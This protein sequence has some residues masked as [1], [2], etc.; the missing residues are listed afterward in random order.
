MTISQPPPEQRSCTGRPLPQTRRP[1]GLHRSST[2]W[3]AVAAAIVAF[4]YLAID[5]IDPYALSIIVYA[6]INVTLAVSLNLINGFTGQFSLGHAGFMA[7]GGYSAGYLSVRLSEIFPGLL[8]GPLATLLFVALL[9]FAGLVAA[10]AGYIVG[11]PSL[12]LKGDYLAIVTLGMAEII[13]VLLLNIDAVGAARGMTGIPQ[14]TSFSAAYLVALGTIFTVSRLLKSPLGRELLA[15]REDEIAAQSI[16]VNTTAAKVSAFVIGAGLAGIAGAL[17]AHYLRYLNPA[18]FD[19][20]RSFEIIIMVVLGGMGSISG[21]VIA[22]IF[23]TVLR[24]AL[25]PLQQLTGV[26][27]RMVIYALLLIVL[28]LTRPNGIFGTREI[29]AYLPARLRRYFASR[30]CASKSGGE[31]A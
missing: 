19:L 26:D 30:H 21:S 14:L 25:R 3:L 23:L 24:E 22:A 8:Q 7:I 15:V 28:M 18:S 6:G 27:L 11:L 12:R 2:A 16:G 5:E 9:C 20:S 10:S 4:D 29:S 1:S 13:R 17:F 31:A